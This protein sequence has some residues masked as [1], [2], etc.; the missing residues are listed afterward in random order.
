MLQ[1]VGDGCSK[2]S[3][4]GSESGLPEDGSVLKSVFCEHG[5][6]SCMK[7]RKQVVSYSGHTVI[8]RTHGSS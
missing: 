8:L 4:D 1:C 7:E 3:S 5:S 6:K 2:Y